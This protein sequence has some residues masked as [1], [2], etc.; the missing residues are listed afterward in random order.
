[1]ISAYPE[2]LCREAKIACE[3]IKVLESS[4]GDC[5]KQ[6]RLITYCLHSNKKNILFSN[7]VYIINRHRH[8]FPNGNVG[9]VILC[10]NSAGGLLDPHDSRSSEHSYNVNCCMFQYSSDT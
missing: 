10:D 8:I 6:K 3:R 9:I 2:F 4:I 5:R 7:E 1:M